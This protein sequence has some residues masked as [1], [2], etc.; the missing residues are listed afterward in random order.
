VAVPCRYYASAYFLA[1]M[2]A[3]TLIYVISPVCFSCIAYWMIGLQ[4]TLG[5]S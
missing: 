5:P 3:E 2:T 4:V 1:K